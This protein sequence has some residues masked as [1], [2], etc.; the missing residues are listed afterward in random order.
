MSRQLAGRLSN[1]L[2]NFLSDLENYIAQLSKRLSTFQAFDRHTHIPPFTRLSV[3]Y[4]LI[5][6][7]NGGSKSITAPFI[8]ALYYNGEILNINSSL[9]RIASKVCLFHRADQTLF[10]FPKFTT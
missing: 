5:V 3:V 1:V 7:V 4:S 6:M 2:Y 10:M 9:Y 8:E